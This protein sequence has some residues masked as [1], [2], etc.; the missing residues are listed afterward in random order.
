M[1]ATLSGLGVFFTVNDFESGIFYTSHSAYSTKDGDL[2]YK[3]Y[4]Y[5]N[6]VVKRLEATKRVKLGKNAILKREGGA[7]F[8]KCTTFIGSATAGR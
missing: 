2:P 5:I 8:P 3:R 7:Q 4:H 1:R 6:Q